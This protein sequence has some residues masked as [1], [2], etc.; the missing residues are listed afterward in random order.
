MASRLFMG[1]QTSH[2]KDAV[3]KQ[4]IVYRKK[5]RAYRNAFVLLL[6]NIQNLG[7]HPALNIIL[8]ID[9]VHIPV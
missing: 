2:Y 9:R 4:I 5:R 1:T 8:V 3:G 7:I 6:Y